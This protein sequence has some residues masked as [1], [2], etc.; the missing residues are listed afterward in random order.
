SDV[1]SSD[2]TVADVDEPVGGPMEDE[3]RDADR[4]QHGAEIVLEVRR[5]DGAYHA[6]PERQP[7]VAPVPA[8]EALV[9]RHARRKKL[10]R[11]TRSPLRLDR[12]ERAP[13]RV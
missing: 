7:L 9:R 12:V 11:R 2:L 13:Q 10:E 6:R 4:G 1:C 3:G 5:D 8:P